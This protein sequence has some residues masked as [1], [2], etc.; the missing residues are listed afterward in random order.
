MGKVLFFDIDG[1]LVN[2]HGVVPA[3][4]K[5]AL[6]QA[7]HAGHQ[8]VI[9]SGRSGHQIPQWIY[10]DFDGL[11]NCTGARVI[12]NGK[13]IDEHFVLAGDVKRAREVLE[14]AHGVLIGQTEE[15]TVLSKE[16][17]DYFYDFLVRIGRPKERIENMLGNA[18]I[19]PAMEECTRIKK[20]FYRRSDKTVEELAEELGD[21]FTIEAA[22]F[23]KDSRDCGEIICKGINKSYG[24]KKYLEYRGV[25]RE[26][27]IAF[28]DG[29][30]DLDMLSYAGIG[31]AMGNGLD[32]VK[33]KADFVT[34]D[35]DEDGIAYAMRELGLIV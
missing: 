4:A 30:N 14:N 16:S 34:K 10:H 8:L 17:Y 6:E 18:I 32:E 19:T 29:P 15:C 22:S 27:A 13:V 7:R 23:E 33:E 3:S 31:V 11:I 12:C 20:F 26:D 35:I 1:T 24:M 5:N 25:S 9:C 28:G 2:S 21:I